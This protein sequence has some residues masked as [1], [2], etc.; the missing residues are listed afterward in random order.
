M[1]TWATEAVSPVEYFTWSALMR[2]VI[3]DHYY[4]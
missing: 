1:N 3:M 4:S 2:M